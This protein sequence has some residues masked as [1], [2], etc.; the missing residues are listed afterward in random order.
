MILQEIIHSGAGDAPRRM[1]AFV[2]A[3][4]RADIVFQGAS[5]RAAIVTCGGLCPGINNVV[6]YACGSVSV[7]VRDGW[8]TDTREMVCVCV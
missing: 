4:P 2:R 1:H 3:G 5:T 8:A 6:R 7:R